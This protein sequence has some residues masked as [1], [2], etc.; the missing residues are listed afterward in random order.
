LGTAYNGTSD[1]GT[2]GPI[3]LSGSGSVSLT[4]TSSGTYAGILIFQGRDNTKALTF[5]GA[6]MQ[7]VTGMIYAPAA[8]LAE[9]GSAQVG[10]SSNPISMVVDTLSLSGAAIA[11]SL[12]LSAAAGTVAYTPAQI[13]AA[14]GISALDAVGPNAT[15][16]GSGQTIAIVDA[17]DDP[18][19]LTAVDTF[20]SQFGLTDSGPSLYAQYG[21]AS[22]FLTVLNQYGQSTS[23]PSTDPTGVGATN[24]EVEEALDVEWVHAMA[25]GAQIILVE[26]NSQSLSDLMA[27]VGTAAAQPGVSVVS[28]SWGFAEGQSVFAADEANYDSVFN[29]PGV[30]FLASTGDYGVDDPEYPAFSPNVVAVG[31]TTLMLSTDNS[32]NSETGW[33]NGSNST[34]PLIGS[35]GGLSLYEP[36]P[37][38]QQGVQSTG[39]RTTPDVSLV[40]DPNTGAWIAD[41]YNLDPSNPFEVVGGTSLSAPAWAGLVALA[42]QGRVAAGEATLNSSSPTE[43]QQALYML[44][45]SDYNVISSGSNGYSAD[46]G[47]NLVTGLGTPV[48]NLLVPD[49]VAYQGSATTYAGPTVGP[50]QD[51]TLGDTGTG[52][53]GPIDVFSVF[54]ALAA[55]GDGWDLSTTQATAGVVAPTR[56]TQDLGPLHGSDRAAI[57][58][59]A[60]VPTIVPGS[61]DSAAPASGAGSFGM[62][63]LTSALT[64]TDAALAGWSSSRSGSP[65]RVVIQ[66]NASRV[67]LRTAA[68]KLALGRARA[69]ALKGKA[70][71]AALEGWKG[72]DVKPE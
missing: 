71:D 39:S 52:G 43:A 53:G 50:L 57:A 37:A 36:E 9:S 19:I 6:A 8:Q 35:G 61:T 66:T 72:V 62:T 64:A 7:G 58:E 60:A 48:A 12:S 28:M 56:T 63:P 20:D 32:Y 15:L 55:R 51:A 27:S 45:Q 30:T 16:D 26:A 1:G 41:T 11:N 24:W 70:V 40:A 34:G 38:Y 22:S 13:R 17:Y 44:P 2:F 33:G 47:Y 67:A 21:P 68:P 54:D 46:S 18:S 4:P 29:V 25:P 49:L 59:R 3:T 65:K 69:V 10:N 14:Y 42:N 31:G 23:L 5:S